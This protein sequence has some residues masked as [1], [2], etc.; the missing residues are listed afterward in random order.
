MYSDNLKQKVLQTCTWACLSVLGQNNASGTIPKAWS[1]VQVVTCVID[2]PFES[3]SQAILVIFISN[4]F[5][6]GFPKSLTSNNDF[7]PLQTI[8]KA[9]VLTKSAATSVAAL[10]EKAE[11]LR[12]QVIYLILW[13]SPVRLAKPVYV[14]SLAP[15]GPSMWTHPLYILTL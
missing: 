11:A 1:G 5:T 4:G 12:K 15:C 10:K 13:S 14:A 8:P 9:S 6:A 2:F 3:S 7:L